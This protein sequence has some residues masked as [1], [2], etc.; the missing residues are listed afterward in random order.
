MSLNEK[1]RERARDIFRKIPIE[2]LKKWTLDSVKHVNSDDFEHKILLITK[3][4]K[5]KVINIGI[6]ACWLKHKLKKRGF[7]AGAIDKIHKRFGKGAFF[8]TS[9]NE[10]D[11]WTKAVEMLDEVSAK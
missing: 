9:D 2:T 6:A 10:E 4:S 5:K 8:S 1:T 7:D 11:I 3:K